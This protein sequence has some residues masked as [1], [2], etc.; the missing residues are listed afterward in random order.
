[1]DHLLLNESLS[2]GLDHAGAAVAQ[3]R[4]DFNNADLYVV[5]D[6]DRSRTTP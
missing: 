1:M 2:A 4:Q 6:I 5:V 3:R